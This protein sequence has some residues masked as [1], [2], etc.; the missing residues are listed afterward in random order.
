[1][2]SDSV[3]AHKRSLALYFTFQPLPSLENFHFKAVPSLFS[4]WEKCIVTVRDDS[5]RAHPPLRVMTEGQAVTLQH[6]PSTLATETIPVSIWT[7]FLC[8]WAKCLIHW[9]SSEPANAE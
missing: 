2:F 1:M 8:H 4:L 6:P 5:L 3:S 7:L 9:A